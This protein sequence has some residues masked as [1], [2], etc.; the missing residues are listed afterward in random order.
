MSTTYEDRKQAR[1]DRYRAR[2]D[3]RETE[4]ARLW[5]ES[6]K[7]ASIIPMG[8]PIL[9]GHHSEQRDRNY[10]ERIHQKGMKAIKAGK[11]AEYWRNRADAAENSRAVSSDD[12]DA[13]EKLRAQLEHAEDSQRVMKAANQIVRQKI[14]DQEKVDRLNKELK[15]GPSA[16]W[17]LLRPDFMG[18]IGFASF[19]LT[20]NSAN[21]RRIK[22]RLA[23]LE[24]REGQETRTRRHNGFEIVENVEENRIQIVFPGKPSE[25]I[26]Q[27]LKGH[28]FRWSPRNG[29]WQ[30]HLN[31]A[32]RAY[33]TIVA[34]KIEEE[35][36]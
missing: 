32:G 30:R 5:D 27:I 33:A 26:R 20:N 13:V 16:A 4:S 36:R 14:T 29:A 10:R 1:I 9:I 22:T 11:E 34:Q 17:Q 24:A 23:E 6:R 12:P 8:Q 31:A 7:M 2:A 35:N 18:R 25:T 15:I 19:Q 21:I 28:G 3:K